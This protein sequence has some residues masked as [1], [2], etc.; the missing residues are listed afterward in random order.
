MKVVIGPEAKEFTLSKPMLAHAS[1]YFDRALNG[2]FEEAKAGVLIM[3]ESTVRAFELAISFIFNFESRFLK[4]DIKDFKSEDE[5]IVSMIELSALSQ[6]LLMP[7]LD[8]CATSNLRSLLD[9]NSASLTSHHVAHAFDLLHEKSEA[10]G[11]IVRT[12]MVH[13][14]GCG[15]DVASRNISVDWK[16]GA[17]LMVPGYMAELLVLM[18]DY[19]MGRFRA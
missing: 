3:H 14:V 15:W 11:A 9:T 17:A 18:K 5:F 6:H 16:Y 4:Y 8:K 19:T 1:P 13:F 12:T 10:R 7:T 2:D